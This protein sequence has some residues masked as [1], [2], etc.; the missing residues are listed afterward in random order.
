MC[1]SPRAHTD[2]VRSPRLLLRC[3]VLPLDHRDLEYDFAANT[4][5]FTSVTSVKFNM[6]NVA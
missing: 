4:N 3:I 5:G 6:P 2:G 1:P